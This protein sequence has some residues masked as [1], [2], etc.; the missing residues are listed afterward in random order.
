MNPKNGK[1]KV[2]VGVVSNFEGIDKFHFTTI[3]EAWL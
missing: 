2:I 3:L 1:E